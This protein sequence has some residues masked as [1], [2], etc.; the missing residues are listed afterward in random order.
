M[1]TFFDV[2]Y[3]SAS[4]DGID[5]LPLCAT[6][7]DLDFS[8]AVHEYIRALEVPVNDL[9]VVHVFD[10]LEDLICVERDQVLAEL[11]EVGEVVL[12]REDEWDV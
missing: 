9:H 10:S 12:H 3:H 1:W 7:T 5:Q 8:L 6:I 2:V 11:V 4:V